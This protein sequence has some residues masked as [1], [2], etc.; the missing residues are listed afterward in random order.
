MKSLTTPDFWQAYAALSSEIKEQAQKAYQLGTLGCAIRLSS[1][2]AYAIAD[3]S[4]CFARSNIPFTIK[5][6][7]N[8]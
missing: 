8:A 7:R 5:L 1:V 3:V 2:S 4:S 6:Y